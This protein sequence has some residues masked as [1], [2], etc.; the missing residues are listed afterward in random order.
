MDA[1]G[2]NILETSKTKDT[3][4]KTVYAEQHG[5]LTDQTTVLETMQEQ[6]TQVETQTVGKPHFLDAVP[7]LS[8]H[9][10]VDKKLP[11]SRKEGHFEK[12]K[13][14][15]LEKQC[16]NAKAAEQELNKTKSS[17]AARA[18][19]GQ[20]SLGY[21][22]ELAVLDKQL[23][24]INAQE[25]EDL[26]AVKL[27]LRQQKDGVAE[28]S[29]DPA[30]SV[31]ALTAR[32][33]WSAQE[34]RYEAY[35][36][37][38]TAMEIGSGA[39]INA[40]KKAEDAKVKAD[41]LRRKY[42]VACMQQGTEKTREGSTVKRH[43]KYD[44][45]KGIFRKPSIYSHE[46]AELT[47]R[48]ENEQNI[49]LENIGRATMGGTKA[50]YEFNEL[51]D[52]AHTDEVQQ[53]WLYKEATNCIG[54]AKPSGA[55]VTGEAYLLQKQLRGEL[56]IPAYCVRVDGKVVG[57]IQKKLQRAE[58]GI[59]LFKWQ[60]QDDLT[61]NAPGETTMHDL[62]NEHT[63]DWVLC[64]FDTK[65][66]NFINQDG[67]HVISF[68]K[69]ASF[70]KLLDDGSRAMSYTYKPH[71]NDTIYNTMF[72]AYAEGTIDLDLY[73]NEESIHSIEAQDVQHYVEMFRGT[74]DAKYKKG[75]KDR[76]EAEER[77]KNRFQ[78]LRET[79]RTFYTDLIHERLTHFQEDSEKHQQERDRLSAYLQNGTFR[80]QD[81]LNSAG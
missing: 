7:Y 30:S 74:L 45:L 20:S 14:Q 10:K 17:V 25:N 40:M 33:E 39:R 16:R 51:Q 22:D 69:E 58:G 62:M 72:R 2:L 9:V 36:Q 21:K 3:Q 59:D 5:E 6:Q 70:N 12:K 80:F 55:I 34:K 54:M 28:K 60:A 26:A 4:A 76:N 75:S 52:N 29:T 41:V 77:L 19:A 64:N 68:D 56:S 31:E 61:V 1:K 66:E 23:K 11:Q 42:K 47:F 49:R 65:G 63:L 78:T 32:V 57:S 37:M 53:Q 13:R 73:A 46:D 15:D 18:T 81:E 79:Y 48:D 35:H 27:L 38:A 67:G 24:L 8:D 71:S 50:M 43:E 44:L